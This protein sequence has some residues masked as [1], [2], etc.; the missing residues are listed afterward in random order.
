MKKEPLSRK[1]TFGIVYLFSS[2]VTTV[3][4]NIVLVGFVARK[5]GVENFG[6]YSTIISFVGLFQF[7][8][9]F[10]LNRTLLKFGST[11][12]KD[13]QFS[14]GNALLLKTI[15]VI[16][17]FILVIFFGYLAGYRNNDI[18]IFQLFTL[19]MV[20]ESYG[21]VFSSIRRILGDFKLVSFFRVLK[22]TINLLIVVVAL[23][24]NNSVLY[25]AFASVLLN[26]V[27]FIIS[28]VNS[29]LLLKPQLKLELIKDF[30]KDSTI[31]SFSDFFNGIYAKLATVLLSFFSPLHS[32]GIFSAAIK[33]TNVANLFPN[34]VRFALLPT[35]YR[36]L[37][38]D[39]RKKLAAPD[40]SHLRQENQK[41]VFKIIL[42][43]MLIFATPFVISIFLFS[44]S[45]MHLI[46][47]R[48][49]DLSIPLVKLFSLF[50][51]FRFIQAPFTL[52]YIAMHRH[53][54]MVYCQ[55]SACFVNLIL[56]LLLIPKHSAY[57]A[58]IA[59]VISD[60]LLLIILIVFGTK[61]LIWD[62]KEVYLMM[63]KPILAGFV[64][65]II[66]YGLLISKVN[67]FLQIFFLVLS[68]LL[69][70][71]IIKVFSKED[72]ELFVKI[73]MKKKM[74]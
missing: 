29:V 65:I 37:D 16:P 61:Y 70:L 11:N 24:I 50:I 59:T 41:R 4:L 47:G 66:T 68:Y 20:L 48:K 55:A 71:I 49:Y 69:T 72:K 14:F 12:I 73:F 23:S 44:D 60:G 57:G 1:L 39:K 67:V 51:Y 43:Y 15:L 10:G 63:Y 34:Q 32:V 5:L 30:F 21:M 45:I 42:K 74:L 31:F 52:F 58:S 17:T 13:A 53:K 56:N 3:A 28:L 25:L 36:I 18:I 27:I 7:L 54:N 19:T 22:T 2:S 46:F 8:S 62:L 9:D 33:F 6:L 64:S 40:E 38:D 35:I 26:S